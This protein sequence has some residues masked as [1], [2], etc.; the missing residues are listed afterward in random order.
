VRGQRGSISITS[1]DKK[2]TKVDLKK[3]LVWKGDT[4]PE[5]SIENIY[6][7]IE[8]SDIVRYIQEKLI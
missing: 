1:P 2:N 3:F 8:P 7:K 4:D 6:Y 5:Y